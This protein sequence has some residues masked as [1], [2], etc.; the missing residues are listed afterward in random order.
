MPLAVP[1]R[2]EVTSVQ[3]VREK[4]S[5]QVKECVGFIDV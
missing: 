4:C 3:F 2:L 5:T 1:R